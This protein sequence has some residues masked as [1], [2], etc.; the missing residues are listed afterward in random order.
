[1]PTGAAY[2]ELSIH[3]F[4]RQRG[5]V[6]ISDYLLL[7]SKERITQ[8]TRGGDAWIFRFPSL[9]KTGILTRV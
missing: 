4:D 2:S 5:L 3:E 8:R 9:A 7:I 1:M 6:I